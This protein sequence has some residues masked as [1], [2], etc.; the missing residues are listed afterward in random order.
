METSLTSPSTWSAPMSQH[1]DHLSD[2]DHDDMDAFLKAVL[3]DYKSGAIQQDKA[4][5][6]LAHVFGALDQRNYAEV[7]SWF[8]QGRKFIREIS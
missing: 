1:D 3:D 2:K 4:V 5:G 8:Q 6:A 7:R